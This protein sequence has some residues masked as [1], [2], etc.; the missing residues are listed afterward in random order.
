MV[1]DDIKQAVEA[2]IALLS[3][4]SEGLAMAALYAARPVVIMETSRKWS[5]F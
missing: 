3:R 4:Y 2:S 1:R 5:L